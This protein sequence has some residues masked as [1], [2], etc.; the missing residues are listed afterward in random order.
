VLRR[1]GDRDQPLVQ[2]RA[3][4]VGDAGGAEGGEGVAQPV[5]DRLVPAGRVGVVRRV[6]ARRVLVRP[7]LVRITHGGQRTPAYGGSVDPSTA[8]PASRTLT[9]AAA[10]A[11]T[12]AVGTALLAVAHT[13]A[14]IPLL[15]RLGP[16]G[17]AVPPAVV[18]FGVGTLLFG[19]IAW[20]LARRE[21]WAWTLGLGVAA[22][23]V[24]SGVGQFR[25][26]V[27]AVGIAISLALA[28]LLLAPASRS[29][30]GRG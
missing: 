21:R 9:A 24:L 29:A 2:P 25:G 18:A 6:P 3:L 14:S 15:S 26:V 10:L 23:S 11:A 7:V 12:A 17:G 28:A 22:L 16:Q 20:G 30:V 8:A 1:S 5:G 13:G 4:L 19:A 27:S